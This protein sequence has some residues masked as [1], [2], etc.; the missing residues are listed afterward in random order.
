MFKVL[1]P[2]HVLT[3]PNIY[4]KCNSSIIRVSMGWAWVGPWNAEA[5]TRAM[6]VGSHLTG[7]GPI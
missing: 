1:V 7:V 4:Y 2:E 5:R 6:S 3:Q